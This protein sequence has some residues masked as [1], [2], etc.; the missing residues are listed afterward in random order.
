MVGQSQTQYNVY[1]LS[2]RSPYG[3][4]MLLPHHK[5][6]PCNGSGTWGNLDWRYHETEPLLT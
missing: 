2:A 5:F 1:M 6:S 4:V 3:S